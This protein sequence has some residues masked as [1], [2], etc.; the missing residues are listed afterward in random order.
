MPITDERLHLIPGRM[1]SKRNSEVVFNQAGVD[2]PDAI[3]NRISDV[4]SWPAQIGRQENYY[5]LAEKSLIGLKKILP[6]LVARRPLEDSASLLLLDRHGLGILAAVDRVA[7][8][9]WTA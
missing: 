8:T 4:L 7:P 1:A 3:E 5:Q 2:W 9:A 6:V